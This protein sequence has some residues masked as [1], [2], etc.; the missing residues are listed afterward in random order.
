L[1]VRA[2]L[3]QSLPA[4]GGAQS[5]AERRQFSD[6][7]NRMNRK[8]LPLFQTKGRRLFITKRS[9]KRFLE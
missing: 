8:N 1:K 7:I 9:S 5:P 3:S 4:F 6:R 2:S